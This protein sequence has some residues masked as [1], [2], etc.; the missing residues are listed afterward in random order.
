M[1]IF[2]SSE[3]VEIKNP[4]KTFVWHDVFNQIK[5][6]TNGNIVKL[7]LV[8]STR[9]KLYFHVVSLHGVNLFLDEPYVGAGF[10][11][12]PTNDKI[13]CL[14]I[15]TGIGAL[16]GGYAGDANPIAKLFSKTNKYLLTHP[17]VVNG[18]V[19]SDIP[20]NTIYLE[21]YLLDQF[22][23]GGISIIP[24][25]KNKIGVIFDKGIDSKRLDYEINVLNAL[26]TF[27]GCN[28]EC[29][30]ITEKPILVKPEIN[31]H[32]FSTGEIL[33]IDCLIDKALELKQD[34][35]TAIAICV[36]MPD[37]ELNK[38]YIFGEGIDPIGGIESLISHA[39]SSV[40][41]LVSAHAPVLTDTPDVDYK[42][43]SPLSAS[44]YIALTFLPSVISG[45]RYS[46]TVIKSSVDKGLTNNNIGQIIV[47]YNGFGS[48]GVLFLASM[49]NE[50][51]FL[52]KE[53]QTCLN[54][55][56]KDIRINFN[57]VEKYLDLIP[58]KVLHESPINLNV[59]R[60]PV[61]KISPSQSALFAKY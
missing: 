8:K 55:D 39:V 4:S 46:P 60:R 33:N 32:G 44:E 47:P 59:L 51:I 20:E 34:G 43:I 7:N 56:P 30:T 6:K 35:I 49:L 37:P 9:E 52:V 24:N 31:E 12:A 45:L 25:N 41:G 42:N 38:K 58:E 13:T 2:L 5:D 14:I 28:I 61:K 29:Y 57:I 36:S 19:L 48:A 18:A 17:N 22:L 26:Q 10:K 21:G 3:I 1:A 54:V 15:P 50:K 11:L 16:Y 27:Y 23:L 40:T 53:N